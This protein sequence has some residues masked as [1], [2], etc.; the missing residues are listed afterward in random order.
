MP[1]DLVASFAELH[2]LIHLLL[3]EE[4]DRYVDDWAGRH[5]D[6]PHLEP[7]RAI[8]IL[9]KYVRRCAMCWL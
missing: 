6:F 3:S 7:S 5:R 9:N 1:V 2:E 8:V 4:F